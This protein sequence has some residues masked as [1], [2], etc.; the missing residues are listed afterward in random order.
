MRA[1]GIIRR[2][3][4]LGR[5]VIPKEIRKQLGIKESD[6]LEL[7]ID[8]SSGDIILRRFEVSLEGYIT[9][10]QELVLEHGNYNSK[11]L[12]EIQKHIDKIKQILKEEDEE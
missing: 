10:F 4:D 11:H 7:F 5:V 12:S 2:V 9:H 1:T 3:D 8:T 6:P